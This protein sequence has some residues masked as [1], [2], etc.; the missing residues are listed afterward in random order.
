MKKGEERRVSWLS[1]QSL[2]DSYSVQVF[3]GETP[4]RIVVGK[5][6]IAFNVVSLFEKG[7]SPLWLF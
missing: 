6:G 4:I 2:S 5:E 1:P 7:S 3:I